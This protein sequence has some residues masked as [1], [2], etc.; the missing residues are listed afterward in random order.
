MIT[1]LSHL[2]HPWWNR[3]SKV[4]RWWLWTLVEGV[5]WCFF[6]WCYRLCPIPRRPTLGCCTRCCHLLAACWVVT[7]S[8]LALASM[9]WYLP[10]FHLWVKVFVWKRL[11]ILAERQCLYCLSCQDHQARAGT[12]QDPEHPSWRL[13]N[14]CWGLRRTKMRV[15]IALL[16]SSPRTH[17][18]WRLG[19]SE[20]S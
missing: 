15:A 9:F 5:D 2:L 8:I 6:H 7:F 10:A 16:L 14:R 17:P 13:V 11:R 18:D 12:H 4:T 19:V 20:E 1:T 3:P